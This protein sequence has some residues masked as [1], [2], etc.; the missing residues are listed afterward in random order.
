[1]KTA[2]RRIIDV[3]FTLV[4]LPILT[5]LFALVMLAVV[6]ESPGNPF[7][8][9]WRIGKGGRRFR[10]WKFR[11][12]VKNA[13]RVGTA[14]TTRR[15]PRITKVGWFLRATK[16][17][18]LPQFINLLVGDLTLIGPR[19]EAPEFV[20]QYTKE[21]REILKVKPGITG[22]TQLHYTVLEAET[23]PDGQDAE[24]FYVEQVMDKKLRLDL[25]YIEKRTFFSDCRVVLE[26]ISLMVRALA[27]SVSR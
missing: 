17:D 4:V 3:V 18:E 24:R 26:T 23:V 27:E 19:P 16:I 15:D 7:Y 11:T 2:M 13:D 14:I 1:M 21:Q 25:E 9:G 5:P 22:P 10:M 20:E 8:G 12:M 6:I